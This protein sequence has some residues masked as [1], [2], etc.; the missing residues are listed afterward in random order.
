MI[1]NLID[2]KDFRIKFAAARK[3]VDM[4]QEEVC[5]KL[6]ISKSTLVDIEH[7]KKDV[8]TEQLEKFAKIYKVP[9]KDLFFLKKDTN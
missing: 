9:D 7:Y 1:G 3:N 4:T 8:T 2:I 5:K 6:N